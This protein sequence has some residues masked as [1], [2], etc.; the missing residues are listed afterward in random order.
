MHWMKCLRVINLPYYLFLMS[1]INCSRLIVLF[2]LSLESIN[3]QVF[4]TV[5]DR[6]HQLLYSN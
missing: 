5:A 6:F 3:F 1:R 2:C 4:Q